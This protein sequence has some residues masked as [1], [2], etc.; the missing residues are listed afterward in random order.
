[1]EIELCLKI[2]MYL[3][4]FCMKL[5]CLKLFLGLYS[6]LENLTAKL[7]VMFKFG[8]QRYLYDGNLTVQG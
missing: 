3:E 8:Y 2:F 7:V 6:L 1:M 5:F 4:T